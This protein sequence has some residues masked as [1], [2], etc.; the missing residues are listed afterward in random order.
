MVMRRMPVVVD[1]S[2]AAFYLK[3]GRKCLYGTGYHPKFYPME[4]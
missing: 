3:F 2:A 1:G 4:N